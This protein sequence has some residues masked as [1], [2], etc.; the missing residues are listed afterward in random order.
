MP[1]YPHAVY[2]DERGQKQQLR[3]DELHDRN[4]R[5][6]ARKAELWDPD[7]QYR[8]FPRY[9]ADTPHFYSLNSGVRSFSRNKENDP[10]HDRRVDYLYKVLS[11]GAGFRIGCYEWDDEGKQFVY[12][13]RTQNYSWGKEVTRALTADV[14]CRHDL[15]GAP[16]GLKLTAR[17]PWIAIEV[18]KHHYPD[19]KTFSAF[20]SLTRELPC[21]ILFDFVAAPNYFLHVN[22]DSGEIRVIYY[23]Y[24]GAVWRN[25]VR[26]DDCTPALFREGVEEQINR[27]RER[28]KERDEK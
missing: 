1:K 17:F 13:T 15:F 28:N 23:I 10:E 21:V 27:L 6:F 12:F 2:Y 26:W 18:V 8:L 20:L 11:S 7:E 19:D 14:Q 16:E 22:R 4:I 25:R 9:R 24:E 5:A 3:P